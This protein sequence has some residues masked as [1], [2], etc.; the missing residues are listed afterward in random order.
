M[1]LAQPAASKR[2]RKQPLE[3]RDHVVLVTEIEE[4]AE[5]TKAYNT[6]DGNYAPPEQL[7]PRAQ[8]QFF[9]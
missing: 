9:R 1:A 2:T 3:L 8:W 6:M 7:D 5:V 4:N